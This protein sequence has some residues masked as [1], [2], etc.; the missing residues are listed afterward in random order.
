MSQF[1][2]EK[3]RYPDSIS[4]SRELHAANSDVV[5]ESSVPLAAPFVAICFI[6]IGTLG[7]VYSIPFSFEEKGA[8]GIPALWLIGGLL[9]GPVLQ[10]LR[11]PKSLLRAEHVVVMS[12]IFWLLLDLVQSRYDVESLRQS[13]SLSFIAVGVFAVGVWISAMM[14]AW[15]LPQWMARTLEG[16]L[17]PATYFSIGLFAFGLAFLRFAI[18]SHFNFITMWEGLSGGRW[19]GPWG[20]GAL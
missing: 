17:P 13:I 11:T 9:L 4:S 18:P 7:A 3:S 5:G 10:I 15:R 1:V 12:P 20:R 8:L 2:P 19:D 6:I 16:D 14:N